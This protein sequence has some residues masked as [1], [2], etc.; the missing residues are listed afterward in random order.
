[1]LNS[2]I[3]VAVTAASNAWAVGG[4]ADS[5]L[6]LR[7]TGSRWIRVP[8]PNPGT[9]AE[10]VGVAATSAGNAW[11]VGSFDDGPQDTLAVHCC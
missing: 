9:S 5:T 8:S 10:L 4:T 7:W 6:I 2:L 11:A 1:M 3:G